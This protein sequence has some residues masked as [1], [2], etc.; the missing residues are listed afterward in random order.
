MGFFGWFKPKSKRYVHFFFE[1]P[2]EPSRELASD[3]ARQ[4][5]VS[6]SDLPAS[7]FFL[8]SVDRWPSDPREY[9]VD[10]AKRLKRYPKGNVATLL[11]TGTLDFADGRKLNW[12]VAQIIGPFEVK[13][14][15]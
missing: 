7:M 12:F 5:K 6:L 11:T 3:L 8:H 2:I 15:K 4:A 13:S 9:A 1:R 14:T 10:T